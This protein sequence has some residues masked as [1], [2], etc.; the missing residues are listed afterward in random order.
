MITNDV[1]T[2]AILLSAY[3]S[4][5]TNKSSQSKNPYLKNVDTQKA[6]VVILTT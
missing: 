2:I 4:L 6:N 3:D 5:K 1:R